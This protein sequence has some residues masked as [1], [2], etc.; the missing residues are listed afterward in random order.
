MTAV[1]G[2]LCS[3]LLAQTA[4]KGAAN[5]IDIPILAVRV[6][7]D[8][9][10]RRTPITPIEIKRWVDHGNYIYAP[11]GIQ[12][13]YKTADG[14]VE[15][16]STRLNNFNGN[17]DPD[18][19]ESR[20]A[21]NRVAAE[22]PGKLTL[23]FRHGPGPHPISHAFSWIDSDFVIMPAFSVAS[24]CGRP[25]MGTFPHEVGH[26]LGLWHTFA[27]TF[28]TL[29]QAD[30]W[31]KDHKGDVSSF[32]GDGLSDTAPD[33]LINALSCEHTSQVVLQGK[34][35]KFD[36]ENIMGYWYSPHH[37]LSRQQIEIVRWV[38]RRRLQSGMLL[39]NPLRQSPVEAEGL[40]ITERRG[41]HT[42]V[43]DMEKYGPGNWSGHAQLWIGGQPGDGLTLTVPVAKAGRYGLGVYLT[44][45]PDFG[46][47]QFGLDGERLGTPIDLYAPRVIASGR[48][49]LTTRNFSAG[50]HTVR[51]GIAGK[52]P[53]SRG[54]A[55]G[56]DCFEFT[57]EEP[58][59]KPSQTR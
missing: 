58:A 19:Q 36:R 55:V 38:A 10:R 56:I 9:G 43:Q 54:N 42:N 52:S 41:V 27:K 39:S 18:W 48:V 7:D 47:V 8:D 23:I 28:E 45:A 32:D 6:S 15:L 51:V 22:H 37:T 21:A 57:A 40:E 31:L 30:E 4:L 44:M 13:L 2:I 20:R 5:R 1:A 53:E 12:F 29:A 33:P 49:V 11:S 25:N 16:K 59:S 35:V 24:V 14:M 26:F 3:T 46:Q 50:R 34:T 17:S